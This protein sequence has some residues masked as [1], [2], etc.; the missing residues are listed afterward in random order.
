M[1]TL[2]ISAL[3]CAS[4]ARLD[5][6]TLLT[7][8]AMWNS[9]EIPGPPTPFFPISPPH[10]PPSLAIALTHD[11]SLTWND[12]WDDKHHGKIYRRPRQ[13]LSPPVYPHA[14]KQFYELFQK[15]ESQYDGV[16]AMLVRCDTIP[17]LPPPPPPPP[18]LHLLIY[19]ISASRVSL[20][21]CSSHTSL[22][23]H[24]TLRPHPSPEP[25]RVAI[26]T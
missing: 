12:F 8:P 15:D 1:F 26:R 24:P 17:L 22:R 13:W 23:P 2:A 21:F 20:F 10:L 6:D 5:P 18:S 4:S 7:P 3:F 11:P 25:T 9:F 14:T 16:Y 19:S